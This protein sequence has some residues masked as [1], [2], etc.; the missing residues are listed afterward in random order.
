MKYLFDFSLKKFMGL[1]LLLKSNENIS[2]NK[3]IAGAVGSTKTPIYR[4]LI[5]KLL[6][7][8]SDV[9]CIPSI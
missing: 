5:P 1:L 3:A 8:N 7:L 2:D 4:N 9:F 6:G